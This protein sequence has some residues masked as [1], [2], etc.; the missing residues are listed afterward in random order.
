[1]IDDKLL[2]RY[3]RFVNRNDMVVRIPPSYLGQAPADS[4]LASASIHHEFAVTTL[5][6]T[7]P[8]QQG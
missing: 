4:R 1:M 6:G 8:Q 7:D 3:A 5:L 2:G